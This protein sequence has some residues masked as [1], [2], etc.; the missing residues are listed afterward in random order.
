[1]ADRFGAALVCLSFKFLF[2]LAT[3]AFRGVE[4]LGVFDVGLAAR[5]VFRAGGLDD[6]FRVILD[7]RLPFVAFR[8]SI[9]KVLKQTGIR[10]AVGEV[11]WAQIMLKTLSARHPHRR[12]FRLD[13]RMSRKD[14]ASKLIV[15]SAAF[16]F[17]VPEQSSPLMM[18]ELQIRRTSVPVL[19]FAKVP[20]GSGCKC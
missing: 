10:S 2:D 1:L 8:G 4:W 9:I 15:S 20:A 7:I 18:Q 17:E 16:L 5:V 13:R 3:A 6:F 19:T 14:A 11:G 12:F